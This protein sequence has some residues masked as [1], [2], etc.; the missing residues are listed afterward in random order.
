MPEPILTP[1]D[2]LEEAAQI[3]IEA[4]NEATDDSGS[5]LESASL[6]LAASRAIRAL[7]ARIPPLPYDLA[8][9]V[10][11][12]NRTPVWPTLGKTAAGLIEAQAAEAARLRDG[13][14]EIIRQFGDTPNGHMA[15]IIARA[16][17]KG[18]DHD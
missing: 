8:G 3:C 4:A 16:A 5:G 6:L 12:L 15:A 11:R 14:Q 10:E 1:A 7:D 18:T 13:L 9:L 2:A 17:L